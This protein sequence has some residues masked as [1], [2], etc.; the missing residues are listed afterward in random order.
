MKNVMVVYGTTEGHTRKIAEQIGE[1]LEEAGHRVM[2][3]D[4]A[5]EPDPSVSMFDAF[6]LAGSLHQEK[7]QSS[8]AHFVKSNLSHLNSKPTLFLSVSLTA[9]VKDEKHQ[10]DASRCI[11]KFLEETGL[12]PTLS[13][14]VA[15]ALLYTKYDFLKRFIM[16]QIAKKEGGEVDTSKDHEYTDWKALK[17]LVMRFMAEK[18]E[19]KEAVRT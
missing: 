8:L 16:L 6:V 14:P 12:K 17:S 11:D 3:W 5:G 15:G 1:W 13:E 19:S 18:V 9:I 2:I 10:A 4:S 7:H